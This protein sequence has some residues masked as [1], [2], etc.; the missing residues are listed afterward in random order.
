MTTLPPERWNG[1]WSPDPM[2]LL[3]DAW[4]G[5]LAQMTANRTNDFVGIDASLLPLLAW[6]NAASAYD[7]TGTEEARREALV[8]ARQ[9]HAL[10][11]TEEAYNLL[12]LVNQTVGRLDYVGDFDSAGN[13]VPRDPGAPLLM[14]GTHSLH[15]ADPNVEDTLRNSDGKSDGRRNPAF[16]WDGHVYR[17]FVN[18]TLVLPV[19][20]TITPLLY[21]VLTESAQR[22]L[23]WTLEVQTVT[24]ESPITVG[25]DLRAK[26][27]SWNYRWIE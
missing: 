13:Y 18:I 4:S 26:F 5:L 7:P 12:L 2:R 23:P 3:V 27:Y 11:G 21:R 8:R 10:S 17:K 6:Q 19:G 14:K 25:L 20:R 9:I 24:I 1:I 15:S 16:V 22:V